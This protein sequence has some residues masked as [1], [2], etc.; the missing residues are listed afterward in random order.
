MLLVAVTS[1][2]P[3]L[4]SIKPSQLFLS[5]FSESY[6]GQPSLAKTACRLRRW[7]RQ[8]QNLARTPPSRQ[9]LGTP[10][11]A[12]TLRSS[13]RMG[14]SIVKPTTVHSRARTRDLLAAKRKGR[15]TGPGKRKGTSEARM[16]TKVLW[17]RR[18]R[19]L[20]RLL[21]KYRD[22]GKIEQPVRFHISCFLRE[23]IHKFSLD[24]SVTTY[25]TKNRRVTCS[26]TS[27][28]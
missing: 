25:S 17:M 27:V 13:S 22:A 24:E 28:F 5:N 19:V 18:Q 9:R 8:A 21:R 6:H 2:N 14:G 16:P 20:R 1:R 11:P 23:F 26:R 10:T 3:R 15:H 4:A 12:Y 7:R